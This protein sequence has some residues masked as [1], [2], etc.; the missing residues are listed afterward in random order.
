MLVV[1]VVMLQNRQVMV[2]SFCCCWCSGD[3]P[4]IPDC[5]GSCSVPGKMGMGEMEG[6]CGIVM[7]DVCGDDMQSLQ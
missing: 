6:D 2:T 1:V 3:T 5:W 4:Q 7:E